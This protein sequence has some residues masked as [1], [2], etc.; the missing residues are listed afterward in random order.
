M[1]AALAAT[2]RT[3]V[4][5]EQR[6]HRLFKGPRTNTRFSTVLMVLRLTPVCSASSAWVQPRASRKA[7]TR[8][9]NSSLK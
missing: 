4:Q 2:R 1:A 6:L 3:A 9:V 8:L 7:R 5:L